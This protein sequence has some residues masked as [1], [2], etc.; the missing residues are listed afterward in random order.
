[1]PS[2]VQFARVLEELLNDRY[3]RNRAALAQAA[4]V[5]PSALSQYVRGKATPSLDVLAH[6]AEALGVSIDYLVFGRD[7]GSVVSESGFLTSHLESGIRKAQTDA[8]NLYDLTARLGA[9]ISEQIRTT[10]K[11]LLPDFGNIAGIL[12]DSEVQELESCS[13]HTTIVTPSLDTEILVLS[14]VEH[15]EVA[16]PSVFAE[17]VVANV[18]KHR[19]Y[20]YFIP[21]GPELAQ[22]ASLLRQLVSR[23]SALPA[24]SVEAYLRIR[25]LPRGCTPG[26]VLYTV[27]LADLQQDAPAIYNRVKYFLKTDPKQPGRAHIATVEPASSSYDMYGLLATESLSYLLSDVEELRRLAATRDRSARDEK[28]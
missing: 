13:T 26:Y 14:T 24:T 5:S 12:T 6:L 7:E 22:Q 23:R 8:A 17:V 15:Q 2:E 21:T 10:A 20:E 1:M 28:G 4:H 27:V 3:K 18:K 25:Q 19:T 11:E 16:A 9:R